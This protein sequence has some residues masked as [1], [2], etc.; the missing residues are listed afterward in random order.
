MADGADP[1]VQR[2]RLA[3]ELRRGRKAV[4]LTQRD[5]IE[6]LDW[7]LS[8]LI[9]IES[10]A[11]GISVTDLKALLDLYGVTDADRIGTLTAAA[12]GSRGQSFWTL[13]RDIVSLQFALYLG[14]ESEAESI[15]VVHPFLIPGL[16]HTEK[17][18]VA[19]MD[20][21]RD[22][23]RTQRIVDL[24]MA[25]QERLFGSGEVT[26]TFV[27]GEEALQRWIGGPH[28]MRRQLERLVD[29][30]QRPDVS[31]KI[32]PFTAGSHPGLQG[33]FNLLHLKETDEEVLFQESGSGDQLTRDEPEK[34]AEY[35]EY[36][37]T[38]SGMALSPNDGEA[39]L[40]EHVD[41]LRRAEEA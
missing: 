16:L 5:V 38:L 20:V 26:S 35:S 17:Y 29:M 12:R 33:P 13:F 19:L 24:R 15:R 4:Q 21:Y 27:L 34:I 9:R 8:K 31:I 10:G 39:L 30:G 41:R 36:F 11:Q 40:H 28:V 2:R 25:R 1:S 23:G 37:E 18:A 22:Q 14:H 7:S 3:V 32:V 6:R